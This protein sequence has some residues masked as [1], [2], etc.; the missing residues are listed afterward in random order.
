MDKSTPALMQVFSISAYPFLSNRPPVRPVGSGF[1]LVVGLLILAMAGNASSAQAQPTSPRPIQAKDLY[2]MQEV[3]EVQL[4]PSGRFVAYTVRGIVSSDSHPSDSGGAGTYRTQL[5]VA[6]TPGNRSP[7]LFTRGASGAR[8]PTWHPDGTHLA[9][10]RPVRGTPQIFVVSLSGGEPYQLTD[11]PHGAQNPKWSPDGEQIL[12]ASTVPQSVIERRTGRPAPSERP[13]RTPGDLIRSPA[14]DTLLVLRHAR[15]LDPV[16]TLAFGPTGRIRPRSDSSRTL[17]APSGPG[18]I[19]SLAAEPVDSL[20]ALSPDSL[21]SVFDRLRLHPDTVTVPVVPDTAA[22]PGGNLVQMRRWMNQNRKRSTAFV[23]TRLDLQ[24]EHRLRPTPTYRHHFLVEVPPNLRSDTP[25]RPQ[26]QPVTTGYRSYGTAE[27]LPGGNQIIVSGTP[28]TDRSPDRVRQRN[29][30][31]M[32]LSRGQMQRLLHIQNYALTDPTLTADGTTVAFRAHAL[33]PRLKRGSPPNTVVD[34]PRSDE[35]AELGLF[36]LNGRSKPRFIASVFDRDVG[37][38]R[39]SPNG[40]FLYATAPSEGGRP[41]YRFTPFARDTS[42]NAQQRP[43]MR[44]DQ[45]TSRDSFAFDST[46]VEPAAYERLT[47][48]PRAV[49]T[50]DLTSATVVYTS[51]DPSTPSALYTNTVSFDNEQQLAAPNADW[52]SRRRLAPS[53]RLTI[54]HDSLSVTGWVTRPATATDSLAHPWLVQV[55]GGPPKLRTPPTPERW[56]ERQYLAARGLGLLEVFPRGATGFGTDFRQA[57]DRNWGPGPAQD[58]LALT[59]SVAA[60]YWTDSTQV[61]L[62]GTAYGATV[63]TWLLGQTDRFEAGVALNGIYDLAAF[64]DGGHAWRLLP[65]EFG[66]YPW[67]GAPVLRS[68]SAALSVG[69][70]PSRRSGSAPRTA[71]HRNSPITYAPQ[72]HTPLL[73]LEGGTNR[74]VG[75]SQSERMYKRL[76]ILDRPVEYVRY[77]GVGHDVSASATPRQRL[78][79]LVRTYEFVMRFLEPPPSSV[80][81][82]A[83]P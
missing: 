15:T 54:S 4:S 13:G 77:P 8:Q 26:A 37:T 71:L 43:R 20:A 57:N 9:F 80:P 6:S 22:A 41:L 44:P 74:R 60:L 62:S 76:K 12:F 66:G 11:F 83:Q 28:P 30:Y 29:L 23:S 27:W 33:T 52:L 50:F 18:V 25:P 78:D 51:T 48:L 69:L 46:M 31:V 56:F 1:C 40:W 42:A 38:I 24:G 7:R 68:D 73:L 5:Y 17:R 3:R 21:R 10:V 14:P 47:E 39:W 70:L 55:R 72:I 49:H 61:A 58:V 63:A 65:Q 79:R 75:L 34:A 2:R 32:D 19:D 81:A 59:D 64:L 53:K 36:A 35:Q 67:E 82:P 16:D 45:S